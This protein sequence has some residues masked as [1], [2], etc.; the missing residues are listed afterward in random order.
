MSDSVRKVA[1][2]NDNGANETKHYVSL[3]VAI[4]LGLIG[5]FGRFIQDSFLATSVANV[6]LIIGA[7]YAISIVFKIMK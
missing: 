1:R 7:V 6:F 4:V 2:S 3:V 5:T